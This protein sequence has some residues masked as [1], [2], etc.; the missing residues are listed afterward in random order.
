[1][2]EKKTLAPKFQ[3]IYW[4]AGLDDRLR[5]HL[6]QRPGNQSAVIR[7]AMER[8]FAAMTARY[9]DLFSLFSDAELETISLLGSLYLR[10]LRDESQTRSRKNARARRSPSGLIPDARAMV[11]AITDD[12]FITACN[13]PLTQVAPIKKRLRGL[14]DFDK[15]VLL[16]LIEVQRNQALD[17]L[18]ETALR[19]EAIQRSTFHTSPEN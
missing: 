19:L 14:P 5:N 15:W 17:T 2:T 4:R 3:A 6:D 9:P 10:A 7:T 12:A 11:K 13:V 18:G 16:D 8:Y 1:M